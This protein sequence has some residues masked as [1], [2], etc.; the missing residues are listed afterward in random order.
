MLSLPL[1]CLG[2]TSVYTTNS[3]PS[4]TT[5]AA[6][7]QPS[8]LL[9]IPLLFRMS[10]QMSPDNTIYWYRLLSITSVFTD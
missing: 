8:A 2:D 1:L 3:I 6:I 4:S 10:F 7:S 9:Y 5:A